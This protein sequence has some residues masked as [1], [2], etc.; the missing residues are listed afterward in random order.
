MTDAM[1]ERRPAGELEAAVMAALPRT[2][3]S[4]PARCRASSPPAWPA[5]P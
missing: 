4:H 3:R 1:D 2:R 5:R